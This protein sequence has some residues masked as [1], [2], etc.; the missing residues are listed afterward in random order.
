MKDNTISPLNY[1]FDSYLKDC[2]T[3]YHIRIIPHHFKSHKIE[4]LTFIDQL[5]TSFSYE[6]DN[7]LTRQNFTKCHEL[8]H[9]ILGHSGK[10]FTEMRDQK[11]T[12]PETEAN[13]FAAFILMPDIVLLSK[14]YYRHDNFRKILSALGVSAEAFKYRLKDLL[15]FRLSKKQEVI[16]LAI[17]HYQ[18]NRSELLLSLFGKIKTE[19]VEEYKSIEVNHLVKVA[20]ELQTLDFVASDSYSDLL[21][22]DFRKELEKADKRIST[23]L[24]YDFGITMGYAWRNDKLTKK[25]AQLRA[26]TLILLEKR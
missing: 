19:I 10:L 24:E 8:G 17:Q 18:N 3:R 7:P 11:E 20:K 25:Q 23:W 14:I 5:G 21:K 2:A 12:L 9:Y 6:K 16:S 15:Q 26:K 22:N 4:G 13:L 1:R